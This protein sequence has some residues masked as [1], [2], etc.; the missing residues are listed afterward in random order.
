MFIFNLYSKLLG[1]ITQSNIK[2]R[3]AKGKINDKQL[4]NLYK[5]A[6]RGRR[7]KGMA[8]L[9]YGIFYKSFI[10]MQE[11]TYLIYREEMERRGLIERAS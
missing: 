11:G 10:N 5:A 3:I 8:I 1:K 7:S 6:E 9:F 2:R 4:T